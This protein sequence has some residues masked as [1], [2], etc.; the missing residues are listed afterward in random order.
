MYKKICFLVA[1]E[2]EALPLIEHFKLRDLQGF[3]GPEMPMK[4]HAGRF[5]DLEISLVT[6]GKDDRYQIDNIGSQPAAVSTLLAIRHFNPELVINAGTAGG[7]RER[8]IQIGDVIIAQGKAWFHDRRIPIPA[9]SEYGLGGY[10][11]PD[12]SALIRELGLKAGTI[13]TGNAFDF[14]EQDRAIMDSLQADIKDMEA[15]SVAWICHLYNTPL[16]IIK[17]VTDYVS[18][19]HPSEEEF[20]LNFELANFRLKEALSSVVNYINSQ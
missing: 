18:L 5:N 1:M 16:L 15:A 8:G 4:A 10:P 9:F 12:H 14:T 17:S 20:I 3:F 13:S 19:Q 2:A 7:F 11:L 6:N